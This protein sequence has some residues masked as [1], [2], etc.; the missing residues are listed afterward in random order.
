MFVQTEPALEIAGGVVYNIT[1]SEQLFPNKTLV[2]SGKIFELGFFTPNGSENQ[3]V[4]IWYKNF[5]PSKIVWVANRNLPLVYTDR[6]AKLTIGSDGNLKL[7]DGQQNIVWSTNASGR[8][9]DTSAALLDS[10]NFVLQDA[11]YSEIWGSFNDPTDTLLPSMKIGVN[12]RTGEKKN[13]ISWRS[14]S[15]PSPGSFL[16]GMTMETPPQFFTWNGSTPHRRSGQWNKLKFIGIQNMGQSY[17]SAINVQQ[18]IQQGTTYLSYKFHDDP[19]FVYMFLSPEGSIKFK[20]WDDGAKVWLT[21][22]E[23]VNNTCEF[24]GTCGP[25]GVCN[26]MSLPICRCLN[27]FVPK[28]IEEWNSENWTGGCVRETELNCLKNTSTLASTIVKKDA[29]WQMSQMKLPDSGDYVPHFGSQ[30]RCLSWCLR[31][32]SCLAYSYVSTIGCMVWTKEDLLDLEEFSTFGEDLFVRVAHVKTGGSLQ[33]EGIISLSIGAGIMLFAVFVFGLCKWRA[34]NRGKPEKPDELLQGNAW[35][36]RLKQDDALELT[37][38]SFDSI[39]L[40][41]NKFSTT[42]KLGQGGFGSV[43][44]GKMN[45]GKE[46][47]VKRL[48]SSSAQGV[49]EFKN[50]IVLI[51]KLQHR[52]LV[53]LIGCCTEGDEKLLVYEYLPNKSLDAFIFV[54]ICL[55]SMPCVRYFPRGPMSIALECCY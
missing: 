39:L 28:S 9:N 50:E 47:A 12:A 40:A 19:F 14:N 3:Y 43:Y 15:D 53:K 23:E 32:C 31:N 35:K 17:L 16:S 37:F 44:K 51:S 5:T 30:E 46:V 27:G 34:K 49:Q 36:E 21:Y 8:S 41:T 29:F 6:S 2:S 48:S 25:F 54:A 26:S 22:W 11:N 45:D 33:K 1:T 10:G 7:V 18:D 24:Y 38:F 20:Y 42:S 13:L 55:L 4:G 52:N